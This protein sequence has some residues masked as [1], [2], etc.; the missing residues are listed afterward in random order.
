MNPKDKSRSWASLNLAASAG[1]YEVVQ[2]V[3][4]HNADTNARNNTRWALLNMASYHGR[5]DV[6]RLLLNYGADSKACVMNI[7][8]HCIGHGA[9]ILHT[10]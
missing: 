8:H 10:C 2:T 5:V 6:V 7:R 1:H 9:W 4:K 3:L